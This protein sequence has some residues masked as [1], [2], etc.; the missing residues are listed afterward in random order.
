MKTIILFGLRRSGNHFLI[1][2]ILQQYSNYVHINN[3]ELDYDNYIKYKNIKKSKSRSDNKW[4]GFLDT[5]CIVISIENKI[6]NFNE[7]EKFNNIDNCYS[8]ILLR[9]PYSNFSSIWKIYDNHKEER[10]IRIVNLWKIYAKIFIDDNN[11]LI[12][13]LY[14]EFCLKDDY[15]I[16]SLLKLNIDIKKINRDNYIPWQESSFESKNSKR[17]YDTLETCVFK[18]DEIFLKLIEDKDKEIFN[19]WNIIKSKF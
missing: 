17:V 3:K 7:L 9:C 2:Q 18:D 19:L 10:L 14:D 11:N 5:E 1:S 16:N 13:I 15:I 8:I 12:K 6:I 4:T